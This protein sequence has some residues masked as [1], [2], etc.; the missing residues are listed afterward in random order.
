M[1]DSRQ[2]HGLYPPT[3][4][5]VP[6]KRPGTDH[7][8]PRLHT[9]AF[10]DQTAAPQPIFKPTVNCTAPASQS[11]ST[12]S[13]PPEQRLPYWMDVLGQQ[14]VPME[15]SSAQSLRF[16]ASLESGRLGPLLVHRLRCSAQDIYRTGRAIARDPQE[17]YYLAGD[18]AGRW[19]A[20]Q[21]GRSASLAPGDLIL[22][23]SRQRYEFHFS[24]D[25]DCISVELP[26]AWLQRWL[27]AISPHVARRFDASQGWTAALCA[28]VR[29][30]SPAV[31]AAPPQPAAVLTDQLGTLLALACGEFGTH[32]TAAPA[33]LGERIREQ[34]AER[35]MEPGLTAAAVARELHVSERTL[36]RGLAA[37]GSSFAAL[38]TQRRMAEAQ[39]MLRSPVFGAFTVAAIGARVG[40]LDSSHFIRLCRRHHGQTPGGLRTRRSRQGV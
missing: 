22:I 31:V 18:R 19:C 29:Q 15:V 17:R 20:E 33:D 24:G 25:S 8:N 32:D 27:P 21:N 34:I 40:L 23:A 37:G 14:L 36:H 13:L 9:L 3:P 11:W 4:W 1:A 6:A 35:F 2:L 5:S 39:R 30:L 26:A 16:Q 7:G 10:S 12:L 28:Y 38:L